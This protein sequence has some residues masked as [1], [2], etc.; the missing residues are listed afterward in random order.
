MSR[1]RGKPEMA[2]SEGPQTEL[3]PLT[4]AG[5]Y[6]IL[7]AA[8]LGWMFS[9][10]QMSLMNLAARSATIEFARAGTLDDSPGLSWE[11]LLPTFQ[12]TTDSLARTPSDVALVVKN[13]APSWFARFNS[14]FLLGAA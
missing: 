13:Q 5:R 14:A 9:G 7:G 8:F 10:V 11:R 1:T 12:S 3:L 2:D 4:A 6:L